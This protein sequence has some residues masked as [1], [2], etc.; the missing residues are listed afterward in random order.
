MRIW[1]TPHNKVIV[2]DKGSKSTE[3]ITKHLASSSANGKAIES[4]KGEKK[5]CE[6]THTHTHMYIYEKKKLA[7]IF[8]LFLL[9]NNRKAEKKS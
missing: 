6:Y 4:L 1:L 8:L 3:L 2:E 7:P 5:S 9:E